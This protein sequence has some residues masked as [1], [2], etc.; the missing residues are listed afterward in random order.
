MVRYDEAEFTMGVEYQEIGRYGDA[1]FVDQQPANDV[2]L[3]AFYLDEDEVTVREFALFLTYAA[4]RLYYHDS[5]PIDRVDGGYRP[6]EGTASEPMREVTWQAARDYCRWA[7]KRLPTEAEWEYAATGTDGRTFPWGDDGPNCDRANHYTGRTFCQSGPE[8]VGERP[9]G[10]TPEGVHD[11]GGNVAEWT[12]DWYG[13]YPESD[14]LLENPTG[15]E[16]GTYKAVRGGGFVDSGKFLRSRARRAVPPGGHAEDVGFRCAMDGDG[17]K[18]D[19]VV[20]GDLELPPDENRQTTDRFPAPSAPTAEVAATGL[21]DP[22]AIVEFADLL[23]VVDRGREALLEVDPANGEVTEILA[24]KPGLFDLA[25]GED[26]IYATD[27]MENTIH[28]IVPGMG[29][30]TLA[31]TDSTPGPID[32]RGETVLW[33]ETERLVAYDTST[34]ESTVLSE[35]LTGVVAVALNESNAFYS[36]DGDGDLSAFEIG[37]F[38]LEGGSKSLFLEASD[39]GSEYSAPGLDL[40]PSDRQLYYVLRHDGFPRNGYLCRHPISSPQ[41]Q[42]CLTHTPPHPSALSVVQDS[43]YWAGQKDLVSLGLG[44]NSETFSFPGKL[45]KIAGFHVSETHVFWS[46]PHV[47]RIYR[48]A[49]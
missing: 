38:P 39:V 32:A 35:E 2:R 10:A 11:L 1:W 45:T 8:P 47:G 9:D 19:A 42:T 46:D 7:G 28:E 26:R 30:Q 41:A 21:D 14:Q 5:Q 24:D 6:K 29:T 20:R 3:D 31:S 17:P 4:G 15:P 36:T 33:G 12:N 25:A 49:R 43:V 37:S 22:G 40:G 44:G 34:D 27:R 16:D 13:D 23:Y 48:V 18:S